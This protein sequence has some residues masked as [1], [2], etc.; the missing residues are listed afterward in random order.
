MPSQP[1]PRTTLAAGAEQP[2]ASPGAQSLAAEQQ[3][4][5]QL[6]ASDG[7]LSRG[8]PRLPPKNKRKSNATAPVSASARRDL[9]RAYS[10]DPRHLPSNEEGRVFNESFFTP[11]QL[12][13]LR[14]LDGESA[15]DRQGAKH[16]QA[17]GGAGAYLDRMVSTL[18]APQ[19]A[20]KSLAVA[21]QP[22]RSNAMG[23]ALIVVLPLLLL[24]GAFVAYAT[25]VYTQRRSAEAAAQAK[26]ERI[27]SARAAARRGS[28]RDGKQHGGSSP[29]KSVSP[30]LSPSNPRAHRSGSEEWEVCL[31]DEDV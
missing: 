13:A 19:V 28:D 25:L 30:V 6:S 1:A 26:A 2:A 23:T 31:T 21:A 9:Q 18:I 27:N 22:T 14:S 7:T 8:A 10:A 3:S 24:V 20:E 5:E 12:A 4:G 29:K 16:S 17:L 11:A 15:E